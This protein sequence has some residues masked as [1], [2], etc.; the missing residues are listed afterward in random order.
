MCLRG[1][2]VTPVGSWSESDYYVAS[3]AAR[4]ACEARYP[5]LQLAGVLEAVDVDRKGDA[6]ASTASSTPL[7]PGAE[8]N[9]GDTALTARAVVASPNPP[10]DRDASAPSTPH[11]P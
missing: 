3:R 6:A 9:H 8:P 4:L 2:P 7:T 11:R 1:E 10:P 5:Q